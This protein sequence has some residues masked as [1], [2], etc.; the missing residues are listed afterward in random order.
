[1]TWVVIGLGFVGVLVVLASI[2]SYLLASRPAFRRVPDGATEADRVEIV[3]QWAQERHDRGRFNGGIAVVR[4][5]EPLLLLPLGVADPTTG[6][7]LSTNS[8][9]RLASVSKQ[10]TAVAVMVLVEQGRISLDDPI[11]D[12][13]AGFR[14]Q[15][16]LVRHLLSHTSGIPDQYFKLAGKHRAEI[17]DVLEIADVTRLITDYGDDLSWEPGSKNR[18]SNTDS[19][20]AAAVIEAVAGES[21][22]QFMTDQIFEPLGMADTGV[23]NLLSAPKALPRRAKDLT[24]KGEVLDPSYLDGVAGDGAVHTSLADLVTWDRFWSAN[25]LVSDALL[26]EATSGV[27]LTGGGTADYGFGWVVEDGKV[28]HNGSWLGARTM[29]LRTADGLTVAVLSNSSNSGVEIMA[30]SIV[31]TMTTGR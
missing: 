27:A 31:K 18:Y 3:R 19:V 17:G 14:H 13:L 2:G 9:M 11:A 20:L 29:F 22:E 28:W 4:D 10:F 26:A 30:H 5:G 21:C 12:H 23:W 1:M 8:S 16:V 15:R 6:E 24:K 7:Q 25:D